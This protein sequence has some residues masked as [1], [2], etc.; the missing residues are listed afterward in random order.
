M[1]SIPV[2]GVLTLNR[3]DLLIRLIKSVDYPVDNFVILFQNCSEIPTDIIEKNKNTFIKKY[4]LIGADMNIGVSRGWNYILKN[5][6][7]DK[8][9]WII[10]GDDNYFKAG[11][12]KLIAEGMEQSDKKNCV[13]VG[14]HML[15]NNQII[16]G[17]FSSYIFTE[18]TLNKIGFFDEN[19]FP[20]YFEDNDFWERIC[21]SKEP[22][23]N[24]E[25]AIFIS[26]DENHT[27]SC[28]IQ[29]V[30]ATYR[31]RMDQCYKQNETF[32]IEK[33][34]SIKDN[35]YNTPFNKN[36]KI[37]D[38]PMHKNY[39]SNQ[40]ILLGHTNIPNFEFKIIYF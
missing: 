14:L 30:G 38:T 20:A 39:F 19:I 2:I 29:T 26:G 25:N 16:P 33:W 6:P 10:S 36:Y 9:Y 27:G 37:T 12:L 5:T 23:C 3:H 11:T 22:V 35:K 28:T 32:L 15:Q 7:S 1:N 17:G 40:F 8:G 24:I 4:T 18:K 31:Q 13:F 34:G 21:K